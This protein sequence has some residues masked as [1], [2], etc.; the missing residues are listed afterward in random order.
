MFKR[1]RDDVDPQT[2]YGPL[3][4][5]KA[6]TARRSEAAQD[7][8]IE[9][10]LSQ[11]DT[12]KANIELSV[13][14]DRIKVTNLDRVYWPAEP[15][16]EQPDLTKRDLL[17]YFACVSPLILPHL[18]D[19]PLTM[20]RM[21]EG[22]HGERFYQK[23]WEHTLPPFAASVNIYSESK[24][25]RQDYL[26]CNNLRDIAVAG[27]GRHVGVPCLALA[28]QAECRLRDPEHRLLELAGS[29]G[30]L[31][32]ELSRL[33]GVRHRSVHLLRARRR[34]AP[35]RSSIRLPSRRASRWHSGCAS[36][37]TACR[38]TPIVKTSGK[39]GLHVFVPIER[40]L[41]FDAARQICEAIGRHLMAQ[42]PQD[43]TMD[44][45]V[46]KRTGKIFM[47]YNMN[48]R[49]KTLNVAYS[50]RGAPGAPMSMP[51]TWDELKKAHPLDY[52]LHNVID[53]LR[54]AGTC[55][56]MRSFAST[57]WRRS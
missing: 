13:G 19:R 53:R 3:T 17:R 32:A 57:A 29:A 40:T 23:H 1:L 28:R 26:M 51:L 43:I 47:D 8:L 11:L 41:T 14:S 4:P 50:P 55:G 25:E 36:C 49:A 45:A 7:P 9:E 39:T 37:C 42:H 52:R 24:D 33:P 44:W 31:G 12:K 18:A 20:I 15:A 48:V 46:K 5:A 10:I 21:P 22:I 6:R 2:L 30:K 56:K 34:P 35:S 38:S 27:A 54:G 16:L